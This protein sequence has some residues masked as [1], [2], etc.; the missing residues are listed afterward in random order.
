MDSLVD[1]IEV[2]F[3]ITCCQGLHIVEREVAA[4]AHFPIKVNFSPF[5]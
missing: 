1:S 4:G 2:D 5:R 3:D